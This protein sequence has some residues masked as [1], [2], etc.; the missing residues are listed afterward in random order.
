MIEIDPLIVK[1]D[2]D[3]AYDHLVT[4]GIDFNEIIDTELFD[5]VAGYVSIESN[6]SNTKV[7]LARIRHSPQLYLESEM[8]FGSTPVKNHVLIAGE[9]YLC[10]SLSESESI[11]FI[12]EINPKDSLT[13]IRSINPI[14]FSEEGMILI[15]AGKTFEGKSVPAFYIDSHE[16]TNKEYFAFI[17]AGGYRLSDIWP[18]ELILIKTVVSQ[19]DALNSFVDQTGIPAPRHWSGGKY[20]AGT[21]NL[22]V[23]GI[24][25]Y[26]ANAYA[27]WVGKQLP[28]WQQWWRAAVDTG[29]RIYPWGNDITTISERANFGSVA[30]LDVGSFLLGISP[31]GCFD[32]A[33]NVSEWLRDSNGFEVPAQTAGGSWQNPTYMFEPTHA[34]PFKRDYSS[35][36][37]GFRCVKPTKKE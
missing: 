19:K 16:V 31:F 6:P 35:A 30:A 25:W 21:D 5:R 23:T 20:P 7:S 24:T 28:D 3:A 36:D 1:G 37:I 13:I 11:G 34:Q 12:F 17:S 8:P 27:L 9:Y 15:E 18:D 10:L 2:Y 14:G 4:T 22:P 32:M 29:D 26:E 33:G